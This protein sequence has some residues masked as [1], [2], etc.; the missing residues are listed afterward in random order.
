MAIRR[1]LL[2]LRLILAI[3][4]G[5]ALTAAMVAAATIGFAHAGLVRSEAVVLASMLGFPLS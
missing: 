4:G 5:Y 3:G 1:I 2:P